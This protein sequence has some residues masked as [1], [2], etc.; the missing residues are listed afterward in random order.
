[1]F[2]RTL[3]RDRERSAR[4]CRV[5][6]LAGGLSVPGKSRAR[7]HVPV[8]RDVISG[9]AASPKDRRPSSWD[10]DGVASPRIRECGIESRSRSCSFQNGL[11]SGAVICRIT[12]AVSGH[13]SLLTLPRRCLRR[14]PVDHDGRGRTRPADA[15]FRLSASG[16]T[17]GDVN[18]APDDART[19]PAA[20]GNPDLADGLDARHDR[21]RIPRAGGR[22]PLPL[23]RRLPPDVRS[24]WLAQRIP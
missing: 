9:V 6:V 8:T 18:G 16:S 19:R 21:A 15:A 3:R 20:L 7:G 2:P 22:Q 5:R 11:D 14:F 1:M 23:V 17:L 4:V 13:S 10:R 24:V 12:C